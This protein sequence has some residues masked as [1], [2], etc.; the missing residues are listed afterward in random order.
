MWDIKGNYGLGASDSRFEKTPSVKR[1]EKHGMTDTVYFIW[2]GRNLNKRET[3]TFPHFLS[4]L[5]AIHNL[6]PQ[7]VVIFL[8]REP[9]IDMWLY[10]TWLGEL[11]ELYPFIKSLHTGSC[12]DG[13]KPSLG[14]IMKTLQKYGGIYIDN[15]VLVL[16]MTLG[17][18]M[19]PQ[20][21]VFRVDRYTGGIAILGIAKNSS[22]IANIAG[23]EAIGR[24]LSVKQVNENSTALD[25][26]TCVQMTSEFTP[27]V[28][29]D[30]ERDNNFNKLARQVFYGAKT[31]PKPVRHEDP[32]I[33][34]IAH[35]VWLG[36]GE[37]DFLFYLSVLSLLHIV[38]VDAVNIHG[39]R[40]PA[41]AL[42]RNVSGD[43]RVHYVYHN[44]MTRF[45]TGPFENLIQHQADL[46]KHDLMYAYGGIFVDCD[47]MF[48]QPIPEDFYH[49]DAVVTLDNYVFPMPPFPDVLNLGVSMHK[50][51]SKFL[52]I[53]KQADALTWQD[54][55]YVWNSNRVPYKIYE[56]NP[57]LVKID[58]TLQVICYDL[59]CY[60]TWVPSY[61]RQDSAKLA[62]SSETWVNRVLSFHWT[63]PSPAEF[64]NAS[65]LHRRSSTFFGK[66]GQKVLQA[67]K[68]WRGSVN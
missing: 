14:F 47:A 11:R 55:D 56:R 53:F 58:P 52:E 2:C 21:R 51:R 59:K 66:L 15:A 63:E 28:L 12:C 25:H 3:F 18:R 22:L 1:D 46:V 34:N 4:L 16:N 64:V 36:G 19:S 42:W 43:P 49:Y 62:N 8:S 45:G 24:C 68:L 9:T 32:V 6:Q 57:H 20:P 31:I 13:N 61:R 33:P 23:E 41:G 35:F 50:P 65:E 54:E 7:S 30:E 5:S 67:A 17:T 60:P 38:K 39:D 27:S 40:P 29:L 37:M 44:R 26:V 48:I 10:N